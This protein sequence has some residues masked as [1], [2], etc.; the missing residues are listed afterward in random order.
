MRAIADADAPNRELVV[1]VGD[2]RDLFY[3]PRH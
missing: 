1:Q 2:I 3:C